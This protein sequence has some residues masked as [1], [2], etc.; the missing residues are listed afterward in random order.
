MSLFT[1]IRFI[2][3]VKPDFRDDFEGIAY[4]GEW[5]QHKDPILKA[6]GDVGKAFLIPCGAVQCM[7]GNWKDPGF[8]TQYDEN[9]GLWIFACSFTDYGN[10]FDE[11]FKIIP[12]FI[13]KVVF[14]EKYTEDTKF[15][16][17][18]GIVDGVVQIV[19]PKFN[20]YL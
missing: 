5:D 13:E 2:G 10:T 4:K 14:L 16:E 11:W 9:N 20:Y 19:N 17:L 18:Y 3:Y 12:H 6:F 8:K 15:S 7:P 1:G